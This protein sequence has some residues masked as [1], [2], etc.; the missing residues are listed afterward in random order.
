MDAKIENTIRGMHYDGLKLAA[1]AIQTKAQFTLFDIPVFG[2]M[3]GRY[4]THICHINEMIRVV[5]NP[6]LLKCYKVAIVTVAVFFTIP[7]LP[8]FAVIDLSRFALFHTTVLSDKLAHFS[9]PK[10]SSLIAKI[11]HILPFL[12]TNKAAVENAQARPAESLPPLSDDCSICMVDILPNEVLVE[13]PGCLPACQQFRMHKHCFA[14]WKKQKDECPRCHTP[15]PEKAL[16]F[17]LSLYIAR[18]AK[19]FQYHA[20]DFTKSL[21]KVYANYITIQ[22]ATLLNH[23]KNKNIPTKTRDFLGIKVIS[24]LEPGATKYTDIYL[25]KSSNLVVYSDANLLDM[26]NAETNKRQQERQRNHEIELARIEQEGAQRIARIREEG[27]QE[28]ARIREKN[29]REIARINMCG[30]I[31]LAAAVF[32]TFYFLESIRK[33]ISAA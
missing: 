23:L 33:N 6:F 30:N 17:R 24:I 28:V 9:A 4:Y 25:H 13:R 18:S 21:D 10:L 5:P 7:F 20:T 31:I 16:A 22:P 2:R 26:I 1:V 15:E 29:A 14:E 8:F 11:Q 3:F 32:A 12:K 19:I 27:E